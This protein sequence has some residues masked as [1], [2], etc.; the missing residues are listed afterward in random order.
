MI[1]KGDTSMSVDFR[2][3]DLFAEL[4]RNLGVGV[5]SNA[6]VLSNFWIIYIYRTTTDMT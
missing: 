2:E 3:I 6:P 5:Q 1:K 4:K